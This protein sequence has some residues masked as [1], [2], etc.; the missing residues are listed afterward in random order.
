MMLVIYGQTAGTGALVAT[1]ENCAA[2]IGGGAGGIVVINGGTVTAQAGGD[3]DDGHAAAIGFG[4][5][6]TAQG[7]V[8]FGD[9]F[10]W[11]VR[12]GDDPSSTIDV[13]AEEY[14]MIIA[15]LTRMSNR[16][17]Q[18]ARRLSPR[19]LNPRPANVDSRSRSS[20]RRA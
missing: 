16:G 1:G 3:D 15:P 14:S 2:G 4:A 10:V 12:K 7:F 6:H 19:R 17:R 18:Y 20:R 11:V 5:G 8:V 13:T 9:R